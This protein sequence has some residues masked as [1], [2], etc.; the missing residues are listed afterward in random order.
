MPTLENVWAWLTTAAS[1]DVAD[2]GINWAENQDA[3]T[4][5]NSAR[6]MMAAIKKWANVNSG[7]VT[8]GGTADA[9]TITT[10]QAIS[11]GHQA[12]G[13]RICF[14][15]AATNTGAATVAVDG[16]SAVAIKRPNNDA[17]SAGDIVSGGF[18]DIAFDGTNYRL[19]AATGA[20]GTYGALSGGNTWTGTNSFNGTTTVGDDVSDAVVIKG[21]AVSAYFAS[22]MGVSSASAFRGGIGLGSAS[23]ENI[24]TSGANVP[25]LN[26]G[27]TWS[28]TQ[29]STPSSDL[30]GWIFN[31]PT[32]YS[33]SALYIN[34]TGAQDGSWKIQAYF[35]N[36]GTPIGSIESSLTGGAG[37]T[38]FRS[39]SDD[40]LKR[41]S[42]PIVDS[43]AVIDQLQPIRYRWGR[44]DGPEDFGF[45]A[46][47]L[48]AIVPQAV[49]P[50]KGNPG[51]KDFVPWMIEHGRLE[52][53]LV[54]EIKALRARVAALEAG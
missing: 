2:S 41:A 6:G 8:V 47:A 37:S 32:S 35:L 1:N 51:D 38:A 45:S 12:L 44:D 36:H 22:L 40:R 4:V 27:N 3:N 11:A 7:N 5:N 43:G 50:G 18:H 20:A 33:T 25:L 19:L 34:N 16:L 21:S 53:I 48:H 31:R 14:K 46:Q 13:F 54:A 39:L 26:G 9:I 42:T 49:S 28:A 52:A 23:V 24:G 10:G 29:T 30:Y 17:L 15:A